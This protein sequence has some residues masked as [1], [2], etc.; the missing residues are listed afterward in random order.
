MAA[1]LNIS[2]SRWCQLGF[3]QIMFLYIILYQNQQ[4]KHITWWTMDAGVT[5]IRHN[6][7]FFSYKAVILAAILNISKR[8]IVP[9]GFHSYYVFISHPLPKSTNKTCTLMKIDAG[10]ASIWHNPYFSIIWRPS[11][12]PKQVITDS[13]IGWCVETESAWRPAGNIE[14]FEIF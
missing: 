3:F 12:P 6:R 9:A 4:R 10:E 11:W 13:D 2:K 1:I 14:H 5:C 8:S 7:Y